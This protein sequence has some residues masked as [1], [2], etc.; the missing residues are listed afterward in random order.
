MITKSKVAKIAAGL[1][2]FAFVFSFAF[3]TNAQTTA[4]LEAQIQALLAQIAQL[5]AQTSGGSSSHTFNVDL[6]VGSTGADVT[7]LQQILVSKGFLT[8]PAGVAM[9][10]FGPLTKSAVSAW[11]ASVGL[12]ATGYVGPLSRAKLNAS[13]G[14]TT[15]GSTGGTSSG[16]LHGGAGDITV[17]SRS[18][19]TDDQVLEGDSNAKIEGFEIEA[20]G[21]DVSITSVRVEFEHT[22]SGSTRLDRYVDQVSIMKDGKVVGSADAGD[23]TKN[24]GVYSRN[25]PVSGAVVKDGDTDKFYVAVDALNNID[26]DDLGENWE[27]AIG[28]IRFEDATGAILTNNDS[29]GNGDSS[30][31]ETFSFED[32]S[33]AGDVK[34]TLSED[35]ADVN[36][37]HTVTID[38]NSDTN[39]VDLLSFKVKAKG[40][41][42]NLIEVPFSITST[43]AGVTEILNDI[44]LMADG[45][46]V[47][48]VSLVQ[49][50]GSSSSFASSTVTHATL[51]ISDLD[52]DDVVIDEDDTMT[53][54]LVADINDTDG[55]FTNGDSLAASTSASNWDAEDANGDS[56]TD[57]N[58]SASS[59]GTRFAATGI[60]VEAV[61]TDATVALNDGDSSLDDQGVFTVTFDVTAFDDPAFV[62][63][64][65]TRGTTLSNTG[66]NFIVENASDGTAT[67]TGSIAGTVLECVSN[68][69]TISS[70]R[71]EVGDGDT[72]R[73]RLTI[74]F[75]PVADDIASFRGQLYSVNF[76][77]TNV[78]ATTQEL[79]TP[80]E[81]FQTASKVVQS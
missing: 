63:L 61:S 54:T 44:R 60:I 21:S 7:A 49:D 8:M 24:S 57:L 74:Y 56:V 34:L 23:F 32:L 40:T 5:Q 22:G 1:V 42:L 33:T 14:T 55:A 2:G 69:G 45:E 38:T 36:D 73:F 41:D 52:E 77:D 25:I 71:V 20:D 9:G 65:T 67:T 58:G 46:E 70:N 4:S 47:G 48:T 64:S 18:S 72:T 27:V 43:G 39:D 62:E 68:C 53:F 15:G 19:G 81:D 3:T 31:T 17:T 10:T 6:T 35:D 26:S 80:T 66:A 76:A 51:T 13:A 12:P 28:A 79:T 37:A 59:D 50:G 75:N 16:S 11:Q 78:D 30:F 29:D